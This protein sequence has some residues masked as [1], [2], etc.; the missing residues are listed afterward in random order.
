MASFPIRWWRAILALLQLNRGAAGDGWV[1]P[2]NDITRAILSGRA[3][4]L[5]SPPRAQ[6]IAAPVETPNVT[7]AATS[8]AAAAPA[9]VEIESE[10]PA[11]EKSARRAGRAA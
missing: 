7:A 9:A 5:A 4:L 8:T 11:A 3:L 6:S 2:S 1:E 10:Q